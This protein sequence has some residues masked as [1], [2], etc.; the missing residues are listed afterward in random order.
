MCDFKYKS[1]LLID[2]NYIDN[3]INTM[4]IEAAHFADKIT[5]INVPLDAIEYL[6]L[7]AQ[8]NSLPDI[9][10]LDIRMPGI[11]G[12]QFLKRLEPIKHYFPA[13]LKIYMLTSSFDP[14][15]LQEI[16]EN[17]LITDFIGK[18]LTSEALEEI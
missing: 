16:K 7:C 13:S 9:I 1:V 15:D 3:I 2:D 12:F 10:F 4:L 17:K 14:R 8:T 5:I 6:S 11:D 18:P